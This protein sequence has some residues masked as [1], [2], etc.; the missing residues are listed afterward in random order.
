MLQLLQDGLAK[1]ILD[2]TGGVGAV[3]PNIIVAL[4][5]VILGWVFGVAVGRVLSQIID[6]LRV[7]VW[8]AKAG[9]DK[10]VERSG[11]RLNTGAF[12]G[13]LAKLFFVVVFLIVAL[14][15]LG[16]S[17]VNAFLLSV[18]AYIPNVVVAMFVLFIA[19]VAADIIGSTV[20]G[21]TLVAGSR[22]AHLLGGITRWAI[23]IF[24]LMF[25]FSQL[26]IADQ[27]MSILFTGIV[28]MLALAGGLAFGL[29]GKDAAAEFIREVR[30]EIKEGKK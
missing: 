4:I 9:V 21:T 18:L 5:F 16:L 19:S 17:Q 26:G 14:N 13:W 20:S 7:D 10:F 23:W 11:Y 15:V 30:S 28:A 3:L 27:F 6:A 8:L 25:A 24:A 12:I 2:V 29:G 1:S 22:V